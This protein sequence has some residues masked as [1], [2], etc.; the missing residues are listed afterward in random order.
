MEGFSLLEFA[1]VL[2][3]FAMVLG[4]FLV[5]LTKQI[6][7]QRYSETQKILASAREALLAFAAAN[8][9]LPCPA[10][11]TSNG[12][13]AFPTNPIHGDQ[14]NGICSNFIAGYL[15]ASALGFTPVDD[16]GFAIDSWGLRANRIRYAVS[17]NEFSGNIYLFTA[18][19]AMKTTTG[20][21][22]KDI[23]D[24][25]NTPLTG[26][27]NGTSSRLLYVCASKPTV[28]SGSDCTGATAV[29]APGNAI[30]V[31]Y[32]LG[33]NAADVP[34][35]NSTESVNYTSDSVAKTNP[36]F[37]SRTIATGVADPF[38][39]LVTWIGPNLLIGRMMA[40]GKLP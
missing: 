4:T 6:E 27:I 30:A 18:T 26:T 2:A 12:K 25:S 38:D 19:N 11:S 32:S 21:T 1:I 34:A 29:L 20:V 37:V 17:N 8:G 3:V 10:T 35:A 7:Q 22:L 16:E 13:E 15:P 5:P 33:A 28:V 36:V 40:A 31:I 14:S 24:V 9:R 39:D 23:S